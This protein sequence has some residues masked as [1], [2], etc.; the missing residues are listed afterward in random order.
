MNILI[1][2]ALIIIIVLLIQYKGQ[3]DTIK[4]V[5]KRHKTSLN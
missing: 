2:L 1:I 4:Y 5:E 3:L